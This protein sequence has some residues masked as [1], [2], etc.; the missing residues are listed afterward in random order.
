M[1][2]TASDE[3]TGDAGATAT[4]V[5]PV[6]TTANYQPTIKPPGME[7]PPPVAP[8]PVPTAATNQAL[9]F[10]GVPTSILGEAPMPRYVK[11]AVTPIVHGIVGLVSIVVTALVV[12]WS[13][14][15]VDG[16]NQSSWPLANWRRVYLLFLPN[17][18]YEHLSVIDRSRLTVASIALA[19]CAICVVVWA[20]RLGLNARADGFFGAPLAA[21]ALLSWYM[22][23]IV[24]GHDLNGI[25]DSLGELRFR[26]T[27][28]LIIAV[29]QGLLVRWTF[30]SRLWKAG[31]LP[32][33]SLSYLLWVPVT[34]ANIWL[35][36]SVTYTSFAIDDNGNGH[37]A[38][39]TTEAI[40]RLDQWAVRGTA[41]LVLVALIVVTV[42]QHL[43]LQADR[44]E[45]E[46]YRAGIPTRPL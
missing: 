20:R 1:A 28:A 12:R 16:G 19:V 25:D 9:N 36:G 45:D 3:S 34:V 35:L 29:I 4:T 44:R 15:P 7:D 31:R 41:A 17:E 24:W 8:G 21:G 43:G 32:W 2:G 6:V 10:P 13:L 5:T 46:A 38:W 27:L 11:Y 23:P 30:S 40:V 39:R 26:F 33:P 18:N 14:T 37:S 22:L 42:R